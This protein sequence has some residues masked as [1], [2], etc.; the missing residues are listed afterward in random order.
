MFFVHFAVWWTHYLDSV[1]AAEPGHI[2]LSLLFLELIGDCVN[3]IRLHVYAADVL[4]RYGV[5]RE[6]SRYPPI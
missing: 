2:L 5:D 4:V 3:A 1:S 6:G